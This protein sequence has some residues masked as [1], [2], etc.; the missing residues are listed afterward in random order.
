MI[1]LNAFMPSSEGNR[2]LTTVINL[3]KPCLFVSFKMTSILMVIL[4]FVLTLV[5]C[6]PSA[7]AIIVGSMN[8]GRRPHKKPITLWNIDDGSG[9]KQ[10]TSRV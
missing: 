8:S 5:T 3:P 9:V 4:P 6:L 7:E 1:V 10:A 2:S